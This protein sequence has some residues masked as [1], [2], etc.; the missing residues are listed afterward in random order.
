MNKCSCLNCF[1]IPEPVSVATMLRIDALLSIHVV[2]ERPVQK[3]DVPKYAV[4][5]NAKHAVS[6]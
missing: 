4:N 6:M 5:W 3:A 1:E 2:K